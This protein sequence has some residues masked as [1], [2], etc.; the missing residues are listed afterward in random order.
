[1]TNWIVR[2][3]Q[4]WLSYAF[5]NKNSILNPSKLVIGDLGVSLID[6]PERDEGNPIDPAVQMRSK[7][8]RKTIS[9]D[10]FDFSASVFFT[11]RRCRQLRTFTRYLDKKYFHVTRTDDGW[12]SPVLRAGIHS[13]PRRITSYRYVWNVIWSVI[14]IKTRSYPRGIFFF[15]PFASLSTKFIAVNVHV[16]E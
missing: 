8:D 6:I 3:G 2:K 11:P 15:T 7:C 5:S 14:L 12:F 1:M 13:H 10:S 4:S 16:P 9:S